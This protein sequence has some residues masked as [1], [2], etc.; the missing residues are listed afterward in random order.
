MT[1]RDQHEIEDGAREGLSA[2]SAERATS[3]SPA[4]PHLVRQGFRVPL[5]VYDYLG[6]FERGQTIRVEVRD[7]GIERSV[8]LTPEQTRQ[9]A[10]ELYRLARRV[11]RRLSLA[12]AQRSELSEAPAQPTTGQQN[13]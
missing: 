13:V 11:T 5:G 7:S 2:C 6:A 4:D 1:R 3:A 8:N 9:A 10:R 12:G